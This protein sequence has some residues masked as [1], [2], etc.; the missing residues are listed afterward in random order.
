MS[1]RPRIS[2]FLC[3]QLSATRRFYEARGCD[4]DVGEHEIERPW[5]SGEVEC[6]DEQ[7]RVPDLPA[8]A[9]P[10]EP[11]ELLLDWTSPPVRLLLERSERPELALRVDD[12]LDPCCA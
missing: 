2:V 6:L 10:Q 12:L 4:S 7:A 9:A 5:D 8:V 3:R 1:E 11:M